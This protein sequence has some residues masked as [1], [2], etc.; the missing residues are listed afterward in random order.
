LSLAEV[1]P[2]IVS[3]EIVYLD[4]TTE[5]LENRQVRL[6]IEI[7]EEQTQQAMRRAARR[8]SRQVNIPGF[9]KGKAP[10]DVILQRFGEET[11]RQE[12]AE[13]LIEPTYENALEQE[14]I[15]PYAP[16]VLEAV[17]LHP[18]TFKFTIPLR[19]TVELGDY[20]DYRLKPSKV[21]VSKRE[22]EEALE[23]IR[24]DNA[25]LELVER[26]AAMGDGV[27]IDLVG[28]TAEGE[29]FLNRDDIRLILDAE[30]TDPAPGFAEAIVGMGAGE[31]RTV[32]LPLPGDFPIERLQGKEVN[33]AVNMVEVYEE[34][35]PELD[36]DLARAVGNFDSLKE[37]RQHV[38]ETLR[39]AAQQQADE[40]YAGKVL[41][42][43]LEQAQVEYPPIMLET[44]LDDAVKDLE[45]RVQRETHLALEDYLRFQGKD[46]DQLKE[47]L[48]PYVAARVKR[49]LV[50]SEV[51]RVEGLDVDEEEVGTR[52]DEISA[53]WG[54]RA[55]EMRS[56]LSSDAGRQAVRSHLLGN[57]AV[58]RLVAIAKGEAPE[59]SPATEQE[60]NE[61]EEQGQEIEVMGSKE[62]GEAESV[63]SEKEGQE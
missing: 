35:R 56:S 4:I 1:R 37:L 40:E 11:V 60:G 28:R 48:E 42:A 39:Q 46:I 62:E 5:P 63:E 26:P 12:A 33:F 19:P 41:E 54:V 55:D 16:G 58:Q 32:T 27:A 25:V 30:S 14:G 29:E 31:E 6:T 3:K 53:P 49:L 45:R 57:K 2:D 59:P 43:I 8:I 24:T 22:I 36:D 7:D 47:E 52:I 10:Y 61:E 50:L 21:E 23:N 34:T 20:R 9:R 15:D 51:V 38:K 18:I 13:I 17:E 44:G